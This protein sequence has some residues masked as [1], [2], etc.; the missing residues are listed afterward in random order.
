MVKA[1]RPGSRLWFTVE[2]REQPSR[3]WRPVGQIPQQKLT[4]YLIALGALPQSAGLS[5]QEWKTA[6]PGLLE[7]VTALYAAHPTISTQKG[8]NK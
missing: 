3:D 8:E 2:S 1:G 5:F 4:E 7:K 6:N